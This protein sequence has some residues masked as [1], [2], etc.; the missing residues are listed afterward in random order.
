MFFERGSFDRGFHVYVSRVKSEAKGVLFYVG[1]TGDHSS[2]NAGSVFARFSAHLNP[3]SKGNALT[4]NLA[5]QGLTP[6]LCDFDVFA[7]GPIHQE[8]ASFELHRPKRDEVEAIEFEVACAL[9][10]MGCNVIGS[11]QCSTPLPEHLRPLVA[12]F[13]DAVRDHFNLARAA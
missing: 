7:F 3:K 13:L 5:K 9:K 2:P 11:H 6:G 10:G 12:K 8:Q 4:R 1:R